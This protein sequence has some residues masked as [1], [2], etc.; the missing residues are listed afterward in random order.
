[1]DEQASDDFCEREVRPSGRRAA[2]G[3]PTVN[4]GPLGLGIV[5]GVKGEI[6]IPLLAPPLFAMDA[7]FAAY[8]PLALVSCSQSA[9]LTY[10][11]TGGVRS[12]LP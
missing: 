12:A 7:G 9:A 10:S 3:K 11:A 4:R 8:W 5:K 6:G 1:M 2:T